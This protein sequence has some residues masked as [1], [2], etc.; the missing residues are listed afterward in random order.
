MSRLGEISPISLYVK[1]TRFTL[2][3]CKRCLY[4]LLEPVQPQ[5]PCATAVRWVLKSKAE[6]ESW[7]CVGKRFA[8]RCDSQRFHVSVLDSIFKRAFVLKFLCQLLLCVFR[9]CSV[10][11]SF[12][13]HINESWL[14]VFILQK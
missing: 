8:D 11:F 3:V 10:P 12:T 5:R 4:S 9:L 1:H 2:H 13:R 6:A 14:P 7:S